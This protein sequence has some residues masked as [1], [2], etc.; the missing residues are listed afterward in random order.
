[1]PN[2]L[3]GGMP[4]REKP[5]HIKVLDDLA[6]AFG[7]YSQVPDRVVGMAIAGQ[8][9]N[10]GLEFGQEQLN[11]VVRRICERWEDQNPN[12]E[13]IRNDILQGIKDQAKDWPREENEHF[14]SVVDGLEE[15]K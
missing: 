7:G 5:R 13:E 11:G 3:G 4:P 12:P 10:G 6:A 2:E 15:K 9:N 8:I 14:W 1:M